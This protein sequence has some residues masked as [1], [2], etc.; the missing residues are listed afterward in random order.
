MPDWL[1]FG[2][3]RAAWG[4]VA[5]ANVGAYAVNPTYSLLGAGHLG[6]AMGTFSFGDN[7]PNPNLSPALSTEIEVGTELRF[8]NGRAGVEFTYYSQKTTDDILSATISQASGFNSTSVNIGELT[9]KGIELLLTAT[10][11]QGTGHLGYIVEHSP[12]YEQG[13]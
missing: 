5:T 10:P 1:S 13:G 2:K 6:I 8:F 12:E 3:V 11:V 7:I 9:N 4:Q